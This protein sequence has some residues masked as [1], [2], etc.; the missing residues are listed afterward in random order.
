MR[1]YRLGSAA[2]ALGAAGEAASIRLFDASDN[3]F[4]GGPPPPPP[5][6]PALAIWDVSRN[7]L[8]GEL[9]PVPPPPSLRIFA[10]AGNKLS[11]A[12]PPLMFPVDCGLR[13]LDLSGNALNGSLPESLMGLA[14]A[15]VVNMSVRRCRLTL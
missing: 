8:D 4:T 15:R 13:L 7:S 3:G 1:R 14:S 9:P 11:G 12:V 6:A 5:D 2:A 10:A